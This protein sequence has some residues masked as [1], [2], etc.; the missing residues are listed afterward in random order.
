MKQLFTRHR[1]WAVL[2]AALI[3]LTGVAASAA[4]AAPTTDPSAPGAPATSA[5]LNDLQSGKL[6]LRVG[7]DATFPPFEFTDANGDKMGFDID[8]VR[9][10]AKEAGIKNVEFIQMPFGNIVPALQANQVDVGASAIYISDERAKAIDFSGVYY[11]GGLA[12]FVA[13]DNTTVTSLADLAGKKIAVQV[14]T[15]SVEWLEQNQPKAQLVQVQTNDQMFSS[16]KLGQADAVVTG[17]P[18]GRYF[19]HQQGGLKQVGERLTNEN[20]GY[21][22][23]KQDPAIRDAFNVALTS[24]KS[25]GGYDKLTAKWFGDESTAATGPAKAHGLINISSI[26]NSAGPLWN[27]FVTTMQIIGM[28]LVLSLAFGMLGGFAKLSKVT[29]IRW[30]GTA[31]VSVIRG[32][33]F[34][35]QLFLIY[36]GLPQLGLQLS[37]MVAGVFALGLYSG[38]Y[39]TEIVRGAIQSVDKGQMEA[40]RS[41]GMSSGAALRHIIIPQAFLRML[42]PLGNEF[43][44]LTKNSALVSF[45]TISELFLVGQTIISRTFDALTVYIFIGLVYYV[46]TNVIGFIA[47]TLEKKLAV[48]I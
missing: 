40:A 36:F 8:L 10:L 48:Y 15:K 28:S 45:V 34:I 26:T 9:A 4:T 20:Y 16:V 12:V 24:L 47:N 31:Y 17:Q 11:P 6:S 27:G 25:N 2:L 33:P 44:S 35:V 1:F 43:V 18:G 38:S 37:P 19:I 41:C 22:F 14:G 32:T 29:P 23:Q 5:K 39:V 46:L 13:E 30:L 7:T 42:P 21:A 3:G